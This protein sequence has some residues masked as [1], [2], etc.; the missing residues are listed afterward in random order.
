LKQA[1]EMKGKP[2]AIIAYTVK[3]K[4]VSFIEGNNRYHGKALSKEEL[5]LALQELK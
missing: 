1:K 2:T 4:G 3:G 5:S